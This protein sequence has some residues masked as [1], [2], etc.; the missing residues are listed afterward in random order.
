MD[1]SM[2][3]AKPSS[4]RAPGRRASPPGQH[5]E[6]SHVLRDTSCITRRSKESSKPSAL[7]LPMEAHSLSVTPSIPEEGTVVLMTSNPNGRRKRWRQTFYSYP[8]DNYLC[9]V[10]NCPRLYNISQNIN[11]NNINKCAHEI[12]KKRKPFFS[13]GWERGCK[14]VATYTQYIRKLGTILLL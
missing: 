5:Q 4:H 11:I 14:A 1:L 10:S 2:F 8:S 6:P 7:P 13:G 12:C 3:E 9:R